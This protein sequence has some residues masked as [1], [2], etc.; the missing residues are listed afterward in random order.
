MNLHELTFESC[1]E[2]AG[3]QRSTVGVCRTFR[4]VQT[5]VLYSDAGRFIAFSLVQ[6]S[7]GNNTRENE[8]GLK[9]NSHIYKCQIKNKSVC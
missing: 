2:A 4:S 6:L 8:T 3:R 5:F 7:S 1:R 9:H